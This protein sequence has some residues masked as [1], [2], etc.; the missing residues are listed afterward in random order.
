MVFVLSTF[1]IAVESLE[2][3]V[4]YIERGSCLV[5]PSCIVNSFP[6]FAGAGSIDDFPHHARKYVHL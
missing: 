3:F 6:F 1:T 5:I 2:M 4:M